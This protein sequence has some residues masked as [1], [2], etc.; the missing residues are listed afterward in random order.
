MVGKQMD[1]GSSPLVGLFIWL[2][3][4][5]IAFRETLKQVI[6]EGWCVEINGR[7]DKTPRRVTYEAGRVSAGQ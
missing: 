1:R 2:C 3:S 7:Y 4:F 6:G 5:G